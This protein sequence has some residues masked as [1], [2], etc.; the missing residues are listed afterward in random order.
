MVSIDWPSDGVA[1]M[2]AGGTR[3]LS[4]HSKLRGKW[5]TT[6]VLALALETAIDK[7]SVSLVA[8]INARPSQ[9]LVPKFG[10][11]VSLSL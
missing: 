5:G 9:P 4:E 8:E 1:Q 3:Q 2:T 11:T 7:S 6:G 10:A